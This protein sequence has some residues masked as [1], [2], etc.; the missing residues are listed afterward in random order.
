MD[1]G[2]NI[3]LRGKVALVTGGTRGIGAECN[4][5]LARA[6]ADIII[7]HYHSDVGRKA[8]DKLEEELLSYG[9]GVLK[10]EADISK[11]DE[12]IEMIKNS[13][14][15]FGSIDI[16]VN[17]AAILI[18]AK[19]EDM[20]FDTW[21]LMVDVILNGTFLVTRYTIPH[22]LANQGGSII[23]ISTN[24]TINGGGSNA[25]YPAAKA[26]MEG[27]AKQLVKEFSQKGIRTNIIQ[28]A[29]I[30]T[31]M[32]RE[33]YPTDKEIAA[34]GKSIPVGRVGKPVDI[35]N[36]VVF[37]A[38]DKSSY[39]CGASLLVDGGRTYYK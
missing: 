29:V 30:D 31:D 3:S 7:N 25:S 33:R 22:M 24:A 13:V 5:Q 27:M 12:V 21:K 9:V 1:K 16:L 18:P 37:F 23:M 34:Y 14:N 6:G 19:F 28:P 35:A 2:F 15:R 20:K 8:A 32:L 36:A 38:S 11:E 10:C 26:G 39:I 17:N 4:R